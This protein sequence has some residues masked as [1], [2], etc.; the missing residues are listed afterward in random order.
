MDQEAGLVMISVKREERLWCCRMEEVSAGVD[1]GNVMKTN[2][3]D[4]IDIN[5]VRVRDTQE[6][7]VGIPLLEGGDCSFHSGMLVGK[8]VC[9][10]TIETSPGQIKARA[11]HE[12]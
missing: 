11:T 2:R 8:R 10:P 1:L 9:L 4:S 3:E 12:W 7:G 6:G 5:R